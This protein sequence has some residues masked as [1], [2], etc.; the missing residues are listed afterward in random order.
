MKEGSEGTNGHYSEAIHRERTS[1]LHRLFLLESPA[2]S[3]GEIL[4]DPGVR[5]SEWMRVSPVYLYNHEYL[6]LKKKTKHRKADIA[7]RKYE[8]ALG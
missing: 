1:I 3:S 4:V 8:F 7:Y 6:R 2:D 5:I